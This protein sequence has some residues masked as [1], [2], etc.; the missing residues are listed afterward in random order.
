MIGQMANLRLFKTSTRVFAA[1]LFASVLPGAPALAQSNEIRALYDRIDRLEQNLTDV[2]SQVYRGNVPPA[3][4]PPAGASSTATGDTP[5]TARLLVRINELEGQIRTLTGKLEELEF[6]V[7][8][9]NSRM[10]KLVEDVDFRLTSI[11]R[12][13]A[14]PTGAAAGAESVPRGA[15]AA[16][17][18]SVTAPAGA[19]PGT[20]GTISPN[21]L[22]QV[23]AVP[24]SGGAAPAQVA[25]GGASILPEGGVKQRYD[26]ARSLLRQG[27]FDSAERAFAEF[28]ETYP[29]DALAGNAQY[30]LGESFYARKDYE[31]AASAFL[32]GYQNYHESPKAPD[33][34][35]KLGITLNALGQKEEACAALGQLN[36]E[37]PNA[38]AAIK[39]RLANE[40]RR[41]GCS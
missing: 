16:G 30:W 27:D 29:E 36:S 4:P 2:Q 15:P 40:Q 35:L 7:G 23:V 9:S 6:L 14:A 32:A 34:L 18:V 25:G 10:D 17:G 26:F 21:D 41:A 37:F 5:A 24:P 11:E 19:P 3:A 1:A 33:N 20:L 28:V 12:N 38:S 22:G 31:R 13:M 8:Q 39:Q